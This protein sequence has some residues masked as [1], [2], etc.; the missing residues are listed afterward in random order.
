M[1]RILSAM[2]LAAVSLLLV[3]ACSGG[4]DTPPAGGTGGT[5]GKPVTDF[6]VPD[7]DKATV[8]GI[9]IDAKTR[10][11]LSGV[12]VSDG[13]LCTRTDANG[14]Y[15]LETDFSTQRCVF[16][17]VPGGYE[18]PVDS[19]S[20]FGGY[21]MIDLNRKDE[22][23][24]FNFAIE[25]RTVSPRNY[26]VLFVGD[27]Q[28]R[29]SIPG[30]H[31]SFETV[32]N[33]LAAYKNESSVP[34]YMVN[35][36]DLTYERPLEHDYFKSQIA[37]TG[38]PTFNI[39]GNHDHIGPLNHD[40]GY[41]PRDHVDEPSLHTQDY[42][43]VTGYIEDFGPNNYSANI[44]NVHY[45]FLDTI[46]W[47]ESDT[48]HP[49]A[50]G[51]WEGDPL[52]HYCE[53]FDEETLEFIRNDLQ[54]VSKDTPLCIVT[55]GSAARTLNSGGEM[56][57]AWLRN[58]DKFNALIAG[59]EVHNWFGHIHTGY[60]YSY[61]D[62]ENGIQ[63]KSLESHQIARATGALYLENEITMDGVPRGFVVAEVSGRKI[64][65]EY[66]R[67]EPALRNG[68]D[69]MQIYTPD[70]ADPYMDS[71][72]YVYVNVFL[73]DNR[74]ATPEWYENGYYVGVFEEYHAEGDPAYEKAWDDWRKDATWDDNR[75]SR[76]PTENDTRHLFRYLPKDGVRSGEVRVEDRF[77]KTWKQ[78]CEW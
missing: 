27:P 65:W 50:G 13:R 56:Y 29:E 61:S 36:G 74:W 48:P 37:R 1:K 71:D 52:Y 45:L 40:T 4:E 47:N 24:Q 66:K 44:G 30:S 39:P 55:H 10:V 64:S 72:G 34:V 22:V 38:I 42:I 23:Q 31:D 70:E 14:M 53:G 19:K 57:P 18:I 69:Q 35:V 46:I 60:N 49:D 54:Y 25:P 11:A 51:V 20:C 3:S 2:A 77:G 16:V 8:K 21:K 26:K 73:H 63:A 62:G 6:T 43:A 78:T 5:G 33:A 75:D 12:V 15:W 59:Y 7:K 68:N 76:G 32:I 9:V 67:A 41:T 17:C 28:I 58:F